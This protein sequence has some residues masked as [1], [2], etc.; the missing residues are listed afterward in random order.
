ME[1]NKITKV[2]EFDKQQNARPYKGSILSAKWEEK[3]TEWG[4]IE[5]LHLEIKPLDF[6]VRGQTGVMH[7]WYKYSPSK[8]S[9]WYLFIKALFDCGIEIDTVDQLQGKILYW[10]NAEYK[11]KDK[12][13]VE[14]V[15]V[16]RLPTLPP[17]NEEEI[18]EETEEKSIE[19]KPIEK[20]IEST[21]FTEALQKQFIHE[22]RNGLT[23]AQMKEFCDTYNISYKELSIFMTEHIN[24][25]EIQHV[26]DIYTW[27]LG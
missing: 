12:N 3:T 9:V 24:K 5:Q 27:V 25:G 17:E 22:L 10:T 20:T 1:N 15:K 13:G 19:Q 7:E 23:K 8:N 16:I 11:Y 18:I 14:Q 21:G 2:S 26:G 6:E 4:K